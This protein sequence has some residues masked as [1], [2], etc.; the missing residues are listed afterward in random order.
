MVIGSATPEVG[1]VIAESVHHFF[2]SEYGSGL[3]EELKHLGLNLGTESE[4]QQT[5]ATDGVLSGKTF[6]VTGTLPS[7]GREEIEELIRLHGGHASSS[8][9]K[10]TSFV[11][12]G[13]NAG[14]KLAKAQSLGV[15]V[16]NEAEFMKLI[17]KA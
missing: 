10:K 1:E 2:H 8:V 14:S 17:G 12:A 3:I 11:V 13:E 16:I 7:M 5:A 9:S 6:V 15:P 4:Q